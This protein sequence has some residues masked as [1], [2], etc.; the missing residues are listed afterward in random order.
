MT[1][2]ADLRYRSRRSPLSSRPLDKVKMEVDDDYDD[3]EEVEE[4]EVLSQRLDRLKR[5]KMKVGGGGGPE[6]QTQHK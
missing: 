3:D 1:S 2:P 5:K 4:E 6:S